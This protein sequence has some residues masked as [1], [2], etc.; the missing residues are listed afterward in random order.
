[1]RGLAIVSRSR[2]SADER[3]AVRLVR[4]VSCTGC[5]AL[6]PAGNSCYCCCTKIGHEAMLA[7]IKVEG[8]ALIEI[9]DTKAHTPVHIILPPISSLQRT[10]QG[11]GQGR[12]LLALP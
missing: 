4:V 10:S 5:T 9:W 3:A 11:P 2:A 8:R 1:M 6:L 12:L 7:T